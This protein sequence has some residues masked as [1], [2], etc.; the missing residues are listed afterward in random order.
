LFAYPSIYPF[1]ITPTGHI[2]S[3][4]LTLNGS[5]DAFLQPLVPFVGRDEIAPHL[6]CQIPQKPQ[7][8]GVNRRFRAKLV[9]STSMH[10][11][12]TTASIPAKFCAAI[13]TTEYP[14]WWSEHTCNKSK[15]ADGR[16]LGK[17]EKSS[18]LGDGLTDFDQIWRSDAV[19]PS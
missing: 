6:G 15:M 18:Y 16:H 4:S 13:K 14:S 11:I 5:N 8:W 12:K 3:S 19:R 2:F 9:K 7:F 17:I 1:F 10:I